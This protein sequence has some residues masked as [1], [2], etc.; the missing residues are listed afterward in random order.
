MDFNY[1]QS[2]EG[3]GTGFW[4]AYGI[5]MVFMLI[6]MWIIFRKAGQPGWAAIIPVYNLLV[7]LR[8][9]GRPWWWIFAFLLPIIPIVGIILYLVVHIFILYGIAKNFGQGAGYTVG[10]VL[11]PIIFFPILAFGKYTWS[12][13]IKS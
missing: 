2:F 11:L 10:L 13:Q 12:A 1:L 5:I 3:M 8:V 7:F 9:A 6:V 4:V